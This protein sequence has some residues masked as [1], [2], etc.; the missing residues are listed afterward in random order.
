[1]QVGLKPK[2]VKKEMAG[3][4]VK[5]EVLLSRVSSWKMSCSHLRGSS[6]RKRSTWYCSYC[7]G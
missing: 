2:E 4:Q 1:M 3:M 7:V 5:L 6:A